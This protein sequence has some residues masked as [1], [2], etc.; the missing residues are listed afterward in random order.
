MVLLQ[1]GSLC[2]IT[3]SLLESLRGAHTERQR[4]GPL[5]CIVTLENG[6]GGGRG[7]N[8]QASQFIPMDP[9]A[10][11]AADARC[12]YKVFPVLNFFT[13]I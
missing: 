12:G 7:T 3:Q 5:E 2:F 11:A 13:I 6:G 10:T 1:P 9:D 8:F 4:Q